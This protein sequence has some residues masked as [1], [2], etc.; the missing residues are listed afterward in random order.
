MNIFH[1]GCFLDLGL[2][3]VSSTFKCIFW[4]F[5]FGNI[6]ILRGKVILYSIG[7]KVE[8]A[9]S[10]KFIN[11]TGICGESKKHWLQPPRS[12]SRQVQSLPHNFYKFTKV[13][14]GWGKGCM[15]KVIPQ[16]DSDYSGETSVLQSINPQGK[17][18]LFISFH[19][20]P[21]KPI[22]PRTLNWF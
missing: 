16:K 1:F 15:L 21:F 6:P 18:S 12:C 10:L 4:S 2:F 13:C 7:R 11:D 14:G 3:Y 20:Q 17:P 22:M 19:K 5:L 8:L 9:N